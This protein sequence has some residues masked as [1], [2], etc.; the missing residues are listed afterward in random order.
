MPISRE[1]FQ[2]YKAERRAI[3]LEQL[4]AQLKGGNR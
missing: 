4:A 1:D 3:P 2:R